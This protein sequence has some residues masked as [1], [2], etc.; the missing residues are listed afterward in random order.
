M[1]KVDANVIPV[2]TPRVLKLNNGEEIFAMMLPDSAKNATVFIKWP[3]KVQLMQRGLEG[4]IG[5]CRWLPFTDQEF[6]A[7]SKSSVVALADLSQEAFE[8]Y[9]RCIFEITNEDAS[10]EGSEEDEEPKEVPRV[11]IN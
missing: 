4:S 10:I 3:M 9:K 8:L 6:I 11:Y 5:L 2:L 1:A 7:V